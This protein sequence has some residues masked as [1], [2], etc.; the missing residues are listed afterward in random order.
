MEI[1]PIRPSVCDLPPA[2][3]SYVELPWHSIQ[4]FFTES[5]SA[6]VS[7]VKIGLVSHLNEIRTR[8][9]QI[10]CPICV[11][12]DIRDLHLVL[13]NM[14]GFH[15]NQRQGA[16]MKWGLRVRRG[17]PPAVS[18]T[19]DVRSSL[20]HCEQCP[21][22]PR[23]TQLCPNGTVWGCPSHGL[24]SAGRQILVATIWVTPAPVTAAE[25]QSYRQLQL[26]V[27]PCQTPSSL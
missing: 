5:C 22:V 20:S 10:Y 19:H 11:Q 9:L 2:T 24:L 25:E 16:Q 14:W 13:F 15:D 6:S 12:I 3:K 4:A 27:V 17:S 21:D 7:S 18:R 23:P 1:T 8:S 26:V